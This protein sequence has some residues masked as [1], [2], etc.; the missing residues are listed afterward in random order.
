MNLDSNPLGILATS[1]ARVGY[2]L[3]VKASAGGGGKGMRAVYEPKMLRT[4]YE[5][6]A[7]EAP[8]ALGMGH[9]LCREIINWFKTC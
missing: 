4:E 1:A 7:R 6:A 8:A 3:L 9:S 2:P 5:A